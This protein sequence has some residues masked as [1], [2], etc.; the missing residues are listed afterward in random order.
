[1]TL[2]RAAGVR[3]RRRRGEAGLD[4]V[5]GGRRDHL[6]RRP[7]PQGR[8]TPRSGSAGT[9]PK[10]PGTVTFNVLVGDRTGKS[11]TLPG[12]ARRGQEH[13]ARQRRPLASGRRRSPSRCWRAH[14]PL[15]PCSSG[16]TCGFAHLPPRDGSKLSARC[17]SSASS[18]TTT[19]GAPRTSSETV[20][21]PSRWS[22]TRHSRSSSTS[23]RRR[24]RTFGSSASSRR[25]PT[26]TTSR[27][28]AGSRVEHGL[29][30]AIHSLA[31][32]EYP[33]EPLA[34]GEIVRA[35][36]TEIRVL[37]TPG[38][39]PEHCAFVV[40]EQARADGR[41]A[42]RRRRGAA[43]PRDRRDAKARRIS[44]ARSSGSRHSATTSRCTRATSPARSAAATCRASARRR[45]VTSA[46]RTTRSPTATC[47]S[48]SSS[49]RR[50]RRR[51]RRRPSA[52]SR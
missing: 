25:T 37:H 26:P 46:R 10:T 28:T 32:A 12:R 7:D 36:A 3:P 48:S 16:S 6:E 51:G 39:R 20:T 2:T 15:A 45:S 52:S 22:S 18:S 21:Q 34:D 23:R 17:S 41:L 27:A 5:D 42:L 1:M 47:R 43:R 11:I 8:S 24:R 4:A 19:S 9:A 38:H 14:W 35:G 31:E 44:S 50:C 49:A 29:P 13:H 40:D 33:C 30:V